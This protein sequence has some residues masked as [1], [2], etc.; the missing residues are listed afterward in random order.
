M[1][2][3]FPAQDTGTRE[4]VWALVCSAGWLLHGNLGI[5][6][7]LLEAWSLLVGLCLG[8]MGLC[9]G[10]REESRAVACMGRGDGEMVCFGFCTSL[11][12]LFICDIYL[13]IKNPPVSKN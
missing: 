1:A 2:G 4:M 5:L 11:M 13:Y 7:M 9:R 10:G 12:I 3:G 8:G 6:A